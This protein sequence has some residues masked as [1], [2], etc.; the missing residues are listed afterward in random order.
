[1]YFNAVEVRIN[2]GKLS[3]V[4]TTPQ[5]VDFEPVFIVC[6]IQTGNF[7]TGEF[8]KHNIFNI[9]SR[10]YGTQQ[11]FPNHVTIKPANIWM[12]EIASPSHLV[13]EETV[14]TTDD[15]RKLNKANS[16]TLK[17]LQSTQKTK[18]KSWAWV[19]V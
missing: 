11:S 12:L 18:R 14:S 15:K 3:I 9:L 17:A 5:E 10:K 16:R 2:H 8:L 6:F 1:M 19:R 13:K 7:K 4:Q